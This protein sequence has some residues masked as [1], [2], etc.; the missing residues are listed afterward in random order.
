[1]ATL[2]ERLRPQEEDL[3]RSMVARYQAEIV[4][5]AASDPEFLENEVGFVTQRC[6]ADVLNSLA[7]DTDGATRG[8]V[9]ESRELSARGPHQGGGLPWVQHACWLVGEE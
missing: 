6:L 4:D 3:A 2:A 9:A 8:Q 1:M 7:T 5:Y